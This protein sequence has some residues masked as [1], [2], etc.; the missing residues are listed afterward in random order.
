MIQTNSISNIPYY[1]VS[2]EVATA[3]AITIYKKS[4]ETENQDYGISLGS[5]NE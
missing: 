5:V 4:S 3:I 2:Q 1:C